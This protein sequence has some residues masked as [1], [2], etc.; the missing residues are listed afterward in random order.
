MLCMRK[1]AEDAETMLLKFNG[2]DGSTL[3]VRLN[4]TVLDQKEKVLA[5]LGIAEEFTH[6]LASNFCGYESFHLA[7]NNKIMQALRMHMTSH[8]Q[9]WLLS[10][11]FRALVDRP[12]DHVR[13][14]FC[15]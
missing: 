3:E 10:L 2:P 5:T 9:P 14:L 4:G 13:K 12:T 8:L 6:L 11:G 7:T 15:C 1:Q